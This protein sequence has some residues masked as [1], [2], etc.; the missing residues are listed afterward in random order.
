MPW[1]SSLPLG[2]NWKV[3]AIVFLAVA[4]VAI[5]ALTVA[6]RALFGHRLR[7]PGGGRARQSR[8]GLVDAFSLDGQRQLVLV[9]RDNVEHLVMIGGLNDIVIESQIVRAQSQAL[10]AR[11]KEAAPPQPPV[12]TPRIVAAAPVPSH[13]APPP[14]TPSA[15][16]GQPH[17]AGPAAPLRPQARPEPPNIAAQTRSAPKP[18]EPAAGLKPAPPTPPAS[19]PAPKPPAATVK[20]P[21]LPPPIVTPTPVAHPKPASPHPGSSQASES[22]PKPAQQPKGPPSETIKGDSFAGLDTLEAEMAKLLGRKT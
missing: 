16:P 6:Y 7:V 11:E 20:S 1:F 14:P 13:G 10:P 18:A 17:P 12:A 9:R 3:Q 5:I 15:P 19:A 22:T 2:D 8:L 21:P 4:V